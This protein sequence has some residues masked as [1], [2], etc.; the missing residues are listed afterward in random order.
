MAPL[1]TNYPGVRATSAYSGL[2]Y[3]AEQSLGRTWN[4]Q[5][6]QKHPLWDKLIKNG[7][8][9]LVSVGASGLKLI[10]PIFGGAMDTTDFV[11]VT[12]ANELT[13]IT[14]A[15]L[16]DG[17]QAEEPLAGYYSKSVRFSK[18]ELD[19][20]KNGNRGD[21]VTGRMDEI[22][23]M[24]Y[25]RLMT[26]LYAGTAGAQDKIMSVNFPL[27]TSNTVHGMSQSSFDNWKSNVDSTGGVFDLTKFFG[28]IQDLRDK[29]SGNPDLAIFARAAAGV[30]IYSRVVNQLRSDTLVLVGPEYT[31]KINAAAA[32]QYLYDGVVFMGDHWA[33][34]GEVLLLTTKSFVFGGDK[35]PKYLKNLEPLDS[36]PAFESII[37]MDC[38]LVCTSPRQNYRYTG[39]TG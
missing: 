26:D 5:Y 3:V 17:T 7:G 35:A 12:R 23:E 28:H 2:A 37:M 9:E 18:K 25:N 11:G 29:K 15:T 30:D 27:S 4:T 33:T 24:A 8:G 36:T 19:Y 21:I 6:A 10:A 16:S 14:A 13:A 20:A 38:A 22:T 34:A 32:S 1:N 39:I 31:G